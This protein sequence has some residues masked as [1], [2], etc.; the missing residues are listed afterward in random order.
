[1]EFAYRK[2]QRCERKTHV[3]SMFVTRNPQNNRAWADTF[4][5]PKTGNINHPWPQYGDWIWICADCVPHVQGLHDH[6]PS[7]FMPNP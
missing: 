5:N 7:H 4:T 6:R 1:M 3:A 2:C